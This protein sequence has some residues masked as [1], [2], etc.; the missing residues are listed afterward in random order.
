M[1]KSLLRNLQ[2]KRP[3]IDTVHLTKKGPIPSFIDLNTGEYCNRKCVFCPR[4]DSSIYPNQHLFMKVELAE[5]IVK[6]LTSIKF[7]GILNICGYGEPLAHPDICQ[8][9]K[10]LSKAS[11]IEIVTNGDLLKLELIQ[12]LFK[13]GLSQ[14]V[15][16]AYDGPHQIKKFSDLMARA[17]INPSLF[18]I[19]SRWFSK[20]DGY[21]I[22][23]TNRAGVINTE[24][25]ESWRMRTCAYP[26]YSL[27]I[28]WNG[29]ILLCVQ[30]WHK[31]LN[32]GNLF[33]ESIENIW[34]SKRMSEYRKNL[35]NGRNCAGFPCTNCDADGM[36]FGKNHL[37]EWKKY[38]N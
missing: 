3:L 37:E 16:S 36:V 21:G 28:D 13:S 10:T 14:L 38:I 26:H 20:E 33:T 27:T 18:N 6:N 1:E 2:R 34:F 12:E 23:L 32:F 31:K 7:K 30:D 25:E 17:N 24:N 29:D 8:I 35:I 5:T 19:R 15:I 9:V 11:H 22:K 4:H